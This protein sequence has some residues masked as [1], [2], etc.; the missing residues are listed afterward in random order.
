MV[1][2]R[3]KKS[4]ENERDTQVRNTANGYVFCRDNVSVPDDLRD[5]AVR[6]VQ[7]LGRTYGAVDIIWNERQNKSFVLEVNAKPGMVGT[8]VEK[9]ANAILRELN[10]IT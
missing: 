6:A 5:L 8:T 4:Y 1:E 9:Y 10:I 7:S 3:K 2:K